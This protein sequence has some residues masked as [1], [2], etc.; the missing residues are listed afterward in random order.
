MGDR[1][2]LERATTILSGLRF[3]PLLLALAGC[4]TVGPGD[5]PSPAIPAGDGDRFQRINRVT[6]RFNLAFDHK[7]LEPVADAYERRT[8]ETVRNRVFNFFENLRGPI[9]IS[10]NFLQGEFR[11]GFSGIGRLLVNSTIGLGGLFDVAAK[12]KM[13][14]HAE[15]F[16]QTLAVWGVPPGP[17]VVLPFLGPSSVRDTVGLAF[18]WRI[19]PLIQYDDT[20]ERNALIIVQQI[21][22][23]TRW[24][25][26]YETELTGSADEDYST[27]RNFYLPYRESEAN[28]IQLPNY[29][30]EFR[31]ARPQDR[32]TS[33]NET[34]E[35]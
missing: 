8:P 26:L 33:A 29:A 17:Y 6:Y 23:R 24:D 3:M 25:S 14:R 5:S 27:T 34:N 10:N 32:G 31:N 18:D 1:G 13:P 21:D 11:H 9:D 4:A 28:G 30:E 20:G 15:D 35:E 16:G 12:L 7:L 19:N 2:G 22:A